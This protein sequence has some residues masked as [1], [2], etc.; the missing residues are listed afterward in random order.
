MITQHED[1]IRPLLT[2]ID[3]L[4]SKLGTLKNSSLLRAKTSL[5]PERK[6]AVRWA[7][8]FKMLIKW[9]RLRE[10]VMAIEFPEDVVAKIPTYA[11]NTLLNS[12]CEDLRCFESISKALQGSGL[13][14]LTLYEARRLFDKLLVDF[15]MKY[16]LSQLKTTSVLVNNPSFENGIIKIQSGCEDRLTRAEK[17]AVSLYLKNVVDAVGDEEKESELPGQA[18]AYADSIL[19]EAQQSKRQR[20]DTTKYRTTIHVLPQSNL[21]ERLFSHAKIIMADRRKHMKPQ[22]LNDVLL[23][24]ANRQLW[25]ASVIQDILNDPMNLE[26]ADDDDSEDEDSDREY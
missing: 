8:L 1:G 7:S 21:C 4:M 5:R 17:E 23:L 3:Q 22:T 20:T 9:K 25:S 16:P 15:G 12:L 14:T 13:N 10:F 18:Q 24:K 11:E 2:K 6:N 19:S 26:D